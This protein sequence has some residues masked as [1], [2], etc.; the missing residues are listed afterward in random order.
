MR[1]HSESKAFTAPAENGKGWVCARTSSK[2][3]ENYRQLSQQKAPRAEANSNLV[4]HYI[5]DTRS[6]SYGLRMKPRGWGGESQNGTL[7]LNDISENRLI[8][9][10]GQETAKSPV[11]SRTQARWS[12]RQKLRTINSSLVD[13]QNQ[14][15]TGKKISSVTD[16]SLLLLC[17]AKEPHQ[18]KDGHHCR[19]NIGMGTLPG[20]LMA[21]CSDTLFTPN[22]HRCIGHC[23]HNPPH[24][25][26]QNRSILK[27]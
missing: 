12:Y 11:F 9:T 1:N 26:P 4:T 7:R 22:N 17:G 25:R 6:A 27:P 13:A 20:T 21:A 2:K 3:I 5:A 23:G 16:N 19:Y 15:L 10:C 14:N 18:Q 24:L 8:A